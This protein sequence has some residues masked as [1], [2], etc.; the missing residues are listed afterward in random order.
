MDQHSKAWTINIFNICYLILI[1]HLN[2]IPHSLGYSLLQNI[3]H[4]Y[5]AKTQHIRMKFLTEAH[6]CIC[7]QYHKHYKD[8]MLKSVTCIA[9]ITISNGFH[10]LRY[11]DDFKILVKSWNFWTKFHHNIQ[12]PTKWSPRT[13]SQPG[14]SRILIIFRYFILMT[15]WK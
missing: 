12:I 13:P 11:F 8:F 6:Q 2:I 15:V 14:T 5:S 7:K 4:Y 10:L 9:F 3:F 1:F